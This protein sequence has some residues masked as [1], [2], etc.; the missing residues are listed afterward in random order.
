[1]KLLK[2]LIILCS[3]NLCGFVFAETFIAVPDL[4]YKREVKQFFYFE[5]S[6]SKSNSNSQNS[7]DV[8]AYDRSRSSS[9]INVDAYRSGQSAS[10]QGNAQ[11]RNRN[12]IG[13]NSSSQSS[14]SNSSESN[15]VKT[16]G[17][18]I[19]IQYS[20]LQGMSGEVRSKLISN[21]F[22]LVQTRPQV[23]QE[24]QNDDFFDII[25]RIKEGEFGQAQYV[26]YGVIAAMEN[27]NLKEKID[28]TDSYMNIYDLN[29]T[30]DY[31]L[32]DT[33]TFEARSAFTVSVSG[34]DSRIDNGKSGP[35][36]PNTSKIMSM[37]S[38]S[39]GDEVIIKL[40]SQAFLD[41]PVGLNTVNQPAFLYQDKPGS[42][43][44]F[45]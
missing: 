43:K 26:L 1:M 19:S 11:F 15:Y 6:N 18:N 14:S 7:Y 4:S 27:R 16:Y 36:T 23:A 13:Y 33:Q 2:K 38:K 40:A 39:L 20:E 30:V 25:R 10:F 32:I 17:D 35:Y 22:K 21:G 31:S 42:L 8:S 45:K 37:A 12:D 24:G 5:A 28:S 29:I 44:V 3:F 41:K 34:N 9:N